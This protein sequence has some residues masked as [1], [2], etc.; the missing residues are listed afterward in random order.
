MIFKLEI[1][2]VVL[3]K[4]EIKF[5][6]LFK[7]KLCWNCVESVGWV[8]LPY[9]HFVLTDPLT[10]HLQTLLQTLHFVKLYTL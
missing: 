8:R 1:Q 6:V 9:T 7:T 10:L 2:F 5:A 3:L 4:F